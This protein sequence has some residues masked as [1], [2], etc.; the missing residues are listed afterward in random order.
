MT[1]TRTTKKNDWHA[2]VVADSVSASSGVRITTML[3]TYPRFVHS[4][5]MT[6]REF[7]RNAASSR[8][9]PVEKK[10]KNIEENPVYPIEWG[11]N[12]AGMQAGEQVAATTQVVAKA[13]WE[14]AL[15]EALVCATVLMDL[16]IHKQVVNRILEPFDWIT[17]LVTSTGWKNFDVLRD[18]PAADPHIRKI[19]R[20]AKEARD[21]STP[22]SLTEGQ[23]HLPFITAED[24]LTL[25]LD[26]LKKVSAGRCARLSY[27][28]FD[29]KRDYSEDVKLFERLVCRAPG[30]EVSDPGHWTPTEHQA[31]PIG[32]WRYGN[33]K[34]WDCAFCAD[35]CEKS[36][37]GR[38]VVLMWMLSREEK[39]CGQCA[40]GHIRSGNFL[41]WKQFRKEFEHEYHS[42]YV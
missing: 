6:H 26:V 35:G 36:T 28:T 15:K 4:E 3:L 39:I 22:I 27:L 8:A 11:A 1:E 38:A 23:W 42:E 41:G 21:A 2:E 14:K 5:L 29:G 19:A 32:G 17:T 16:K 37:H 33:D 10:I 25:Q 34:Y 24:R 20:L 12:K 9:I 13:W 40:S 30:Q 18:H 31:T 7:S